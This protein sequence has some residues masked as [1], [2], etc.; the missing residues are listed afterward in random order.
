[1]RKHLMLGLCLRPLRAVRGRRAGRFL[2]GCLVALVLRTRGVL[3]SDTTAWAPKV[4]KIMAQKVQTSPKMPLFSIPS[5]SRQDLG[6]K[7]PLI[8]TPIWNRPRMDE[9]EPEGSCRILRTSKGRMVS[10]RWYLGSLK[11]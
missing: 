7:A 3:E 4:C 10:I 11:G 8:G 9:R 6:R 2:R 1:M 5:G